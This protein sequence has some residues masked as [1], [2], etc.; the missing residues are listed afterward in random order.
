[1]KSCKMNYQFSQGRGYSF[2]GSG[3]F[4]SQKLLKI[5]IVVVVVVIVIIIIFFF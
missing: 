4:N 2:E 3:S 5:V 1:M